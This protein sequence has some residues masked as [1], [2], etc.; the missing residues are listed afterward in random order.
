MSKINEATDTDFKVIEKLQQLGWKRRDTLLYQRECA[1]N[2]ELQ[3]LWLQCFLN[4]YK[5]LYK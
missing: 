3:K 5:M 1:L 2:P 4:E